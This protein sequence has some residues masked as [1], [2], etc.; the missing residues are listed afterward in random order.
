MG[1]ILLDVTNRKY[2][3]LLHVLKRVKDGE[4][5]TTEIVE[6]LVVE[7]NGPATPAHCEEETGLGTEQILMPGK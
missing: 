2:G 4:D 6:E 7:K 1:D 5:V 3:I